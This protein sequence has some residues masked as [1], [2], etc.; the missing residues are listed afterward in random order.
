MATYLLNIS[1]N[2]KKSLSIFSS[3]HSS[4]PAGISKALCRKFALLKMESAPPLF[5]PSSHSKLDPT[6]TRDDDDR[7]SSAKM[8][9]IE[10][11]KLEI[12]RTFNL[13]KP[14]STQAAAIFYP[15]L[16]EVDPSTKVKAPTK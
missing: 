15:T 8:V 2:Q 10:E 3:T 16:W 14:I 7:S 13:V 12:Q 5:H 1:L 9:D 6:T 4:R 11:Y